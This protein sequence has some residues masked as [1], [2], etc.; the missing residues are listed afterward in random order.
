MGNIENPAFGA[1]SVIKRDS[2]YVFQVLLFFELGP[3]VTCIVLAP[4]GRKSPPCR[5]AGTAAGYCF[6]IDIQTSLNLR[7]RDCCF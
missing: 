2:I 3:I 7:R 1:K 6:G 5:S 4:E